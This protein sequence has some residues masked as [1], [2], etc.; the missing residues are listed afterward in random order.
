M[1]S[2]LDELRKLGG[3]RF[4][5]SLPYGVAALI[6]VAAALILFAMGRHPICE[7]GTIKL[8]HG[9]VNS[10]ENSQH[11][12]DWYTLSHIVHG[13]LFYLALSP[14]KNKLGLSWR[15]AIA[16]LIEALWEVVENSPM[17]IDRYRTATISLDYYG[18]SII[19]SMGDIFAMMLGFMIAARLPV[20][21]TVAL[22]V[23]SE[24][25]MA[26]MIRDNLTL[27]VIMLIHPLDV[28]KAWQAAA[29]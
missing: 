1:A 23:V 14:L 2:P 25:F 21:A 22:G 16:V 18:D 5:S 10:S 9:V 13:Y 8:W 19:N 20:A 12:T 15:F 27:N 24:L 28:I 3:D 4:G 26:Y 7:C 29:G 11:L 17:I 6:V